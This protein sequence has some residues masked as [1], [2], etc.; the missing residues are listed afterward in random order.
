MGDGD[1]VVTSLKLAKFG[2]PH[3]T[4]LSYFPYHI[5]FYDP[6]G[7]KNDAHSLL[8][9][10]KYRSRIYFTLLKISLLKPNIALDHVI[11]VHFGVSF[12]F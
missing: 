5:K 2:L 9:P 6:S 12:T 3:I 11:V 10:N 1:Q 8:F 4:V 7:T